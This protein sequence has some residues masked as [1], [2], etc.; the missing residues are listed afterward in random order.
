MQRSRGSGLCPKPAPMPA[1]AAHH[2]R[3]RQTTHRP[4]MAWRGTALAVFAGAL[5]RC[6][7]LLRPQAPRCKPTPNRH[8]TR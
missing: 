6:D 3:P 1:A 8:A 2:S 4:H 7:L 5:H